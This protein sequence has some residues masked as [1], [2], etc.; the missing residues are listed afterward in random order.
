MKITVSYLSGPFAAKRARHR[1]DSPGFTLIELLVV[2]AIIAILAAM[3]LPA[4]SSARA[5][6][7][8]TQC[9][10][11]MRQLGLGFSLFAGDNHDN[12]PPAGYKCSG[13]TITW[14]TWIYNYLGVTRNVPRSELVKGVFVRDPVDAA[15]AGVPVAMPILACPADR[16]TKVSWV[17]GPPA[18]GVRSYAMNS[19]GTAYGSGYQIDPRGTYTLPDLYDSRAN[20]H[21]VGIYW[22]DGNARNSTPNWDARGYPTAVVRDTA[23]TILLAE[24]PTGQ[25]AEGNEWT[26]VCNGPQISNGGANGDLYQIDTAA[27]PQN[28]TNPGGVNQGMLLYKAHT[29]RFNYLFHDNHVEALTIEQTIGSG[30]LANPAGMWTVK[31][32]D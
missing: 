31:K 28:P 14:D 19:V 17:A 1:E 11:D 10:S 32:G 13:G 24:E 23:G 25:Q 21:G 4:L 2:I 15:A 30:T 16:F 22:L 3:L 7:L 18:F 9:S 27:R 5:K 20:Y 29:S 6:A 12:Y 8:R 26:C